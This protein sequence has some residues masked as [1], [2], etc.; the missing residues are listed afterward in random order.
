MFDAEMN[1]RILEMSQR[2]ETDKTMSEQDETHTPPPSHFSIVD[3]P[4]GYDGYVSEVDQ[5]IEKQFYDLSGEGERGISYEN[6]RDI[7]YDRMHAVQT[8]LSNMEEARSLAKE[9]EN[10]NDGYGAVIGSEIK[11]TLLSKNVEEKIEKGVQ[12]ISRW[13]MAFEA[14]EEE[15]NLATEVMQSLAAKLDRVRSDTESLLKAYKELYKKYE[16]EKRHR[17]QL[18]TEMEAWGL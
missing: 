10:G 16:S 4:G 5:I 7:T 1:K 9:L 15:K 18:Q 11:Q 14:R 12:D 6:A 13:R 17:K 3:P 2:K 8:L